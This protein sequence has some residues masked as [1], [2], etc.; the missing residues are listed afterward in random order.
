MKY[1][2]CNFLRYLSYIYLKILIFS[3]KYNNNIL[4]FQIFI[5]LLKILINFKFKY[6]DINNG[7]QFY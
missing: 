2:F 3:N 5:I 1:L 4:Y 7:L 6:I